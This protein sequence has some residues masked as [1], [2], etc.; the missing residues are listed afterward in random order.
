[1]AVSIVFND[2]AIRSIGVSGG[3]KDLRVRANRVLNA[4]RRAAP[5]DQGNLRA[6][7]GVEFTV[8]MGD[9]VARVGSNLEYAIYVH[10][11]TG[12]YGPRGAPIFPRSGRFMVWAVRNNNYVATGGSRRYSGGATQEFAFA[13]QTKGVRG[14]PFLIEALSAAGD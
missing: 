3:E 13:R 14:R 9:A 7:I 6:S 10:Q 5:V 11:G 12:I 8:V 2:A 1:M 4:A